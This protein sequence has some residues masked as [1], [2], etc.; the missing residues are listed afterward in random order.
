ME[1]YMQTHVYKTPA[2]IGVC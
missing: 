1:V 2:G